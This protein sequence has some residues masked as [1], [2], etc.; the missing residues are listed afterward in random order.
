M[1]SAQKE[2]ISVDRW[3]DRQQL[4]PGLSVPAIGLIDLRYQACLPRNALPIPDF[5]PDCTVWNQDPSVRT[6]RC[7]RIKP[8][9]CPLEKITMTPQPIGPAEHSSSPIIRRALS[10]LLINMV[11]LPAVAYPQDGA[12]SFKPPQDVQFR[13]RDIISEGTRMSAEVFSLKTAEGKKLPTIILCHG[14]GGVAKDLRPEAI[15]FAIRALGSQP[16]S[17]RFARSLIRSTRR[18]T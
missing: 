8:R 9:I 15:A 16:R 3:L 5:A 12:A 10:V 18:R 2:V 17:R 13:A 4:G 14:W 6:N 1:L 11:L 7:G